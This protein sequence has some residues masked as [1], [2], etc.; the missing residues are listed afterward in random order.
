MPQTLRKPVPA[1]APEL[2]KLHVTCWKETYSDL[3]PEG[4]FDTAHDEHRLSMWTKILND[5]NPRF[6]IAVAETESQ[7][8]VGFA[9]AAHCS[10]DEDDLPADID[11]QLYN[12]YVLSQFHG[13]G[14]G[15]V[16]LDTVLGNEPAMLW[17]ADQNPRAIAFYQRNGFTFDGTTLTDPTAPKITDARMVRTASP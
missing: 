2:A 5:P 13:D 1:D 15:Q 4:S 9:F 12:L 8:L 10:S 16:L 7:K 17:V 14:T 11:T 3:L 6:K